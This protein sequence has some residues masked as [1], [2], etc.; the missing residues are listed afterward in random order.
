M[1][2]YEYTLFSLSCEARWCVIRV[3]GK[4][5]KSMM[6]WMQ[7]LCSRDRALCKYMYAAISSTTIRILP[8][9]YIA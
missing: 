5:R 7:C 2:G 8:V 9:E 6:S 4:T 1:K 3:T